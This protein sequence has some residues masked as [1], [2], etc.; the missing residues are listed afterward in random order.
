MN[1][2]IIISL[3]V[4]VVVLF[5]L[6]HKAWNT[7]FTPL[8]FL[9]LPYVAVLLVSIA[10]SR[11]DYF[12]D[13][14][15]P[16]ILVW[17]V[18][19]L[20]FAIPDYA[21]AE[22]ATKKG[23]PLKKIQI[24]DEPVPVIFVLI[25]IALALLFAYRL[26]SIMNSSQYMIGSDEFAEEFAGHGFWG[27][28][29]RFCSVMLMIYIYYLDKNHRWLWFIIII[30]LVVNVINMVKGT[31]IIPC[32]TG[33]M[34]RLASGKM[35]ITAKFLSLVVLSSVAVFFVTF[36]LAIVV[37]NDMAVNDKVIEWIFQRFV[38]YLTS[39][40]L[41]LSVDMQLGFPDRGPI[42]V[43]WT[44]FLNIIN[45]ITGSGEILSPVNPVFHFTG[46]SLT[47]VRTVFGTLLIY[48][49]YLQYAL[50]IL[51]LSSLCYILKILSI[52]FHN[53]FINTVFYYF[54]A[55]LSMGWFEF[56]F[57]HLDIIEIP[58]MILLLHIL[59][60]LFPNKPDKTVK[61]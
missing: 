1:F 8:S 7:V 47:N 13:F 30:L 23:Y 33:V 51:G 42:D 31:M 34:L 15:Y 40:T 14:Y 28:L 44:P 49:N 41:G 18:G 12:V 56:Y 29:K 3:L 19:L 10:I 25:G 54:C 46:I 16:S 43:I 61:V 45:Q 48:T 55:L 38:H 20:L 32:V 22:F 6:E 21:I 60:L 24:D 59:Y 11:L 9:M 58:A 35:K 17:N 5:Y 52:H 50:Y 2:L 4:E 39:G 37:V 27:H 53:L 57:F 26:Y 36:L